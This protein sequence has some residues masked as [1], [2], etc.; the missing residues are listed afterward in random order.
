MAENDAPAVDLEAP[1]TGDEQPSAV[2]PAQPSI[3]A[4]DQIAAQVG[5]DAAFKAI[6]AQPTVKIRVP[7]VMGPQVV[8]INGARFNV[9]ANVYVE[10][11]QQVAEILRDAGRI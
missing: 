2:T 11:P 9:P 1:I 3:S 5:Q 6:K 10:V 4:A 7:K 8:I